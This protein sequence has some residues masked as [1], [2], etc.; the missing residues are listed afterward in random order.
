MDGTLNKVILIG[1]LGGF[2]SSRKGQE[3][4]Q[5]LN[6]SGAKAGLNLPNIKSSLAKIRMEMARVE[7]DVQQ[8]PGQIFRESFAEVRYA[9]DVCSRHV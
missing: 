7:T 9:P 5:K 1:R 4:F 2:F 6:E 3:Q 8:T